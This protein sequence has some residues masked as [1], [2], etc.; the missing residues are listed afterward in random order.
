MNAWSPTALSIFSR[1]CPYSVTLYRQRRDGEY[2]V[3]GPEA[4]VRGIVF[5]AC[6]HAAAQARKKDEPPWGAIEATAVALAQKHPPAV[7][8]EGRAMAKDFCTEWEFPQSLQYEHGVAFTDKWE[9]CEWGDE[10]MRLRMVFDAVGMGSHQDPVYGEL[11]VAW[12]QDYK[13]G[14][15]VD[16]SELDSIQCD[17]YCTALRKLY[18]KA[19]GIRLDIIATRYMRVHTKVYVFEDDDHM[20]EL[21]E[22]AAR[23]KFFMGAGDAATDGGKAKPRVGMGCLACNYRGQCAAFAEDCKKYTDGILSPTAEPEDVAKRYAIAKSMTKDAEGFLKVHTEKDPLVLP[24]GRIGYTPTTKRALKAASSIADLWSRA[25]GVTL[26]EESRNFVRGL[27][28]A[29]KP[30]VTQFDAVVKAAAKQLGYKNQGAAVAAESQTH[31]EE[32]AGVEW[33]WKPQSGKD[34][35]SAA[36]AAEKE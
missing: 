36:L 7:V 22:R 9:R 6:V 26:D 16:A 23:L 2:E 4:A 29:M 12:A 33:G 10:R 15:Q 24:E 27:L 8:W 14:W 3:E 13:T 25:T 18:P 32:K 1:C 30:G 5:H 21:N 34:K 35:A 11:E 28:I 17:A 20:A 31:C 19:D